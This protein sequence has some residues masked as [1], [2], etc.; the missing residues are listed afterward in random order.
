MNNNNQ[1]PLTHPQLSSITPTSTISPSDST[2][3]SSSITPSN[4]T[5]L[6]VKRR[7]VEA[8]VDA[9]HVNV[10]SSKRA[11]V[12]GEVPCLQQ[13]Y[14]RFRRVNPQEGNL[15][16]AT[17]QIVDVDRALIYPEPLDEDEHDDMMW[18]LYTREPI[19]PIT[20]QHTNFISDQKIVYVSIADLPLDLID[21]SSDAASDDASLSD[22]DAHS[23]DYP[24]TPPHSFDSCHSPRDGY[25]NS[26]EREYCSEDDHDYVEH[27]PD[28]EDLERFEREQVDFY[29]NHTQ[30][31]EDGWR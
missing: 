18:D 9:L 11:R 17:S 19:S 20:Q 8:S 10:P 25:Y 7:R 31:E 13:S 1:F 15:T 16:T 23:I 6:R 27:F 12:E 21:E 24:S 29:D 2:G 5:V 26:E 22:H 4:T 30:V 3:A 14:V 28:D